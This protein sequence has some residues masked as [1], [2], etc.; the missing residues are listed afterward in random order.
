MGRR[1]LPQSRRQLRPRRPDKVPRTQQPTSL[2]GA[3]AGGGGSTGHPPCWGASPLPTAPSSPPPLCAL[4]RPGCGSIP[5]AGSVRA[6]ERRDREGPNPERPR[7]SFRRRSPEL[8]RLLQGVPRD[9]DLWTRAKERSAGRRG[10]RG[11][12]GTGPLARRVRSARPAGMRGD[13]AGAQDEG[14]GRGV[15]T[16]FKR[17]VFPGRETEAQRWELAPPVSQPPDGP[18]SLVGT[19]GP[20]FPGSR[21]PSCDPSAPAGPPSPGTARTSRDWPQP[22]RPPRSAGRAPLSAPPGPGPRPPGPPAPTARRGLLTGARALGSRS[23]RRGR[24]QPRIPGGAGPAPPASRRKLPAAAGGGSSRSGLA[25][26]LGRP[27]RPTRRREAR[28]EQSGAP[29]PGGAEPGDPR[30]L[31]ARPSRP[32][33]RR[34]LPRGPRRARPGAEARVRAERVTAEPTHPR[35]FPPALPAPPPG[36]GEAAAGGAAE[37]GAQSSLPA[38]RPAAARTPLGPLSGRRARVAAPGSPRTPHTPR[39]GRPLAEAGTGSEQNRGPTSAG[40]SSC[41]VKCVTSSHFL[42][43]PPPLPLKGRGGGGGRGK[44]GGRGAFP[45]RQEERDPPACSPC[46]P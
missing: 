43:R 8:A 12:L 11:A 20:N 29:A 22:P 27:A 30:P 35:P 19:T 32:A 13:A 21:S 24:A 46:Q 3:G 25:L 41:L 15:S 1:A 4:S 16:H 34:R 28:P 38:P 5:G 7:G 39:S 45:D 44:E 18:R 23:P 31:R 17:R 42:T 33:R 36:R 40:N 9:R 14:A 10:D 26:A 6:E 2:C 37:A